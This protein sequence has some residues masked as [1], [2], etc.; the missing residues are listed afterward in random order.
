MDRHS[1]DAVDMLKIA[2]QHAYCAEHLLITTKYVRKFSEDGESKSCKFQDYCEFELVV[3][4]SCNL[5]IIDWTR[6]FGSGS[7]WP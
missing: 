3:E 4:E 5:Q 2:A 6:W 1:L 7:Q